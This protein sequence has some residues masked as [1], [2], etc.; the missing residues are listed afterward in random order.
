MTTAGHT[1]LGNNSAVVSALSKAVN[2]QDVALLGLK[3]ASNAVR[4]VRAGP[5]V[6]G[7][8]ASV[9]TEGALFAR[10]AKDAYRKY[11]AGEISLDDFRQQLA[12]VGCEC[13]GGVAASTAGSVIGQLVIPIPVV[14]GVV[15]CTLGNL[16]GRWCGAVIGR[17]LVNVKAN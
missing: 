3:Q 12:K 7:L 13:A 5:V 4:R 10:E 15:G 16:I 14:G 17:K 11:R 1:A 9:T 2:P 8:V 6:G